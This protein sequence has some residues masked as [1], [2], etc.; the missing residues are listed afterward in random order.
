MIILG[1]PKDKVIEDYIEVKD[2][3]S[4]ELNKKGFIPKYRN[5]KFTYYKK[6]EELLKFLEESEN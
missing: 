6:S 1:K 4:I 5:G 3:D 2:S